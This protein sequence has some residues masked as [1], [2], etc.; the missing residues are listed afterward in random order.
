[1]SGAAAAPAKSFPP[2]IVLAILLRFQVK[3]QAS[4]LACSFNGLDI[5]VKLPHSNSLLEEQRERGKGYCCFFVS[6]EGGVPLAS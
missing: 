1:M 2:G 5:F 4:C 3:F 6:A